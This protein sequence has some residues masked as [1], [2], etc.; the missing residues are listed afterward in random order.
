MNR[1]QY[2][3]EFNKTFEFDFSGKVS[4]GD[5]TEKDLYELFK[6]GRVASRF[7]EHSV[8]E[9]F[10]ELT[11]VDQ[12]GYDHIDKQGVKFDLKGFT[13]LGSVYAPS[14]MIGA[15]RKIN[16]TE[17]HSHAKT[18]NYIFSDITEFPK[19]RL[20]FKKGRDVVTDYP[21]GKIKFKQRTVLFVE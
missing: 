5:L 19:V 9:W 10:P 6:D 16:V 3:V 18:I 15:G 14:N 11:F 13:K 20:V 4:F 2:R 12:T 21:S 1:K 17:M 8:P 7:L